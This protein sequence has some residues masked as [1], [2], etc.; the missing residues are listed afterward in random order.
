MFPQTLQSQ[1]KSS[2]V[3]AVLVI[4]DAKNAVP[5]AKALLAGGIR[6]ME[7]TLRTESALDCIKAVAD[8]VPDMLVGAGTIL[9]PEQAAKAKEAGAQ[10]G[11][12]P[13]C[14]PRVIQAA[15]ALGLPFAPGIMTPSDIESAVEQGCRLLKFFPAETSGGLNHLKAIAAPYAH[16]NINYIPLGGMTATTAIPYLASPLVAAI[17]GSWIASRDEIAN[18][19]WAAITKKSRE[20]SSL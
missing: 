7:L 10:F 19:D 5:L 2:R 17:G 18:Q 9:T 6:S 11:V 12:S 13:G 20:A 3:V 4:D 14:N 8:A 1:I 16:L 15:R